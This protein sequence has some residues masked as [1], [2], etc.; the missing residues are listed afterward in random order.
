M[1]TLRLLT[2]AISMGIAANAAYAMDCSTLPTWQ[3][4]GVYTGGTLVQQEQ[5]VYEANWWTQN[6]SPEQHAGDWKA[7]RF[8]DQCSGG[9]TNAAP[10]AQLNGPFQAQ[11]DQSIQFSSQGSND[12][13]G[14][15]VS[16]L[17][18]F[19]D[20]QT[21]TEA[22]PSHT[23]A[24]VGTYTVTLTVTDNDGASAT[25]S[26]VATIKTSDGDTDQGSCAALPTYIAGSQYGSGDIVV[27]RVTATNTATQFECNI[28]GWCSSAAAWAYEPGNGSYWQD[29]WTELNAC[30]NGNSNEAPLAKPNGPYRGQVN[31]SITF[32]SQGSFDSDGVITAYL[33][34]FGDSTTSTDANPSHVYSTSGNFSVTLT[35]TDDDGASTTASTIANIS[36]DSGNAK[37]SAKANGPYQGKVNEAIAFSSQGSSD[38]DGQ[39]VAYNWDFGDGQ[40]STAVNPTHIYTVAGTYNVTLTV[41]DDE[42]ATSAATAQVTVNAEGDNNADLPH[43]ALVGYWHNFINGAGYL[44]IGDVSPA[45]D[46]VQVSFAE[47]KMGGHE[48]EVA[49]F[50]AEESDASF[51]AGMK[52][53]QDRGQKVLISLGGANA[54]I[55]LNTDAARENF[56]RTMGEII[57]EYGFDGIDIDLEGGS[58]IMTAG[59]TIANAKT[60]AIVNMIQ[61]VRTL[62]ARFG[63]D[64]L[65]TM[66]PETAYVQG[67]Y[68]NFGGIWGAYLPLIHALRDDLTMLH[69]QHYN[70]G[71]ITGADGK[72]YNPSTADFHVAMTDMMITGFPAGMN[73][74]NFFHGLREDQVGFGLP[75]DG[76]S[77]SSGF[78]SAAVAQ[79]A[80]DCLIK[81]ENCD[82]YHPAQARSDLRGL[83]TWSINWDAFSG[84]SFSNPHRTYLNQNP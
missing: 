24:Q 5:K 53:L 43:R 73:P 17:W 46:I 77:A 66:A 34:N 56:I 48:G 61:A 79:Q 12:N 29:A 16:Y 32:N 51:R 13:D 25:S 7:W 1:K 41:T 75:A 65:L 72:N 39:I 33:W 62:K 23:Y 64:F 81:L 11:A 8:V 26:S 35:V 36:D 45:W 15:I 52:K 59:D 20:G 47:N 67:G 22:H 4:T 21:S 9:D 40:S 76:N 38:S 54:H 84:F 70:T 74:S 69:V 18:S 10:T 28:A 68:S 2:L 80:M 42:N 49:F 58:M 30:D 44:P 14:N 55:Q 19:G 63:E 6:E 83:M 82:S 50:P 60:P 71:S 37:P 3:P 27:N 31:H 57:A 78:T